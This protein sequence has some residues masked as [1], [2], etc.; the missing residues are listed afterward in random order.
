MKQQYLDAGQ[1]VSTHGIRGEVKVLPWADGP[2]FLTLFDRVY[3]KGREYVLESA[4]VQKTCVLLKLQGVDT[5]EAA[6]ALRD[7]V[8][9][10]DRE[11]VELEEGTYFIADLIG[12]RV[13]DADDPE[14]VYGELTDVSQ[15]GANDVYH[16]RF[17]DGKERYVPAI[18]QVVIQT[19]LENG[20]LR[21]RPLDGLFD[22]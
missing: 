8:V 6:Q 12:L 16:V 17:A 7:T 19:D 13:V 2:E 1:I 9:Q 5:V 22:D 4:R 11:D 20:V 18:P 14:L 3:L 10:V 21:I 15:T